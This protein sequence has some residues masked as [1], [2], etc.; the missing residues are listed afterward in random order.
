M[1]DDFYSAAKLA[2]LGVMYSMNEA[3]DQYEALL[4]DE[5]IHEASHATTGNGFYDAYTVENEEFFEMVYSYMD[6][7]KEQSKMLQRELGETEH[8][9]PGD[10]SGADILLEAHHLITGDRNRDYS[11][12]VD[13]YTKVVALFKA[14][15]G[16]ELTL[17]QAILFMLSIKF[18]RIRSNLEKGILH[19]DSVADAAGYLGCLNIIHE[20]KPHDMQ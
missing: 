15:T 6:E 17:S 18:A 13:D 9:T 14:M 1:A 12:P 20:N 19:H 11:H 7:L 10:L 3:C 5:H 8:G 2:R 4:Q 16:I